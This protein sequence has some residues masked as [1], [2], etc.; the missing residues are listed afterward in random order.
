MEREYWD[1]REHSKLNKEVEAKA[2]EVQ[3]GEPMFL[4]GIQWWIEKRCDLLGLHAPER[5]QS[6]VQNQVICEDQGKKSPSPRAELVMILK[7]A[8]NP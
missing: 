3:V 6:D 8:K 7:S 4:A 5:Q 1:A 2:E